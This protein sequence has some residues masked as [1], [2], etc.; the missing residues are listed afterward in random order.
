MI[1]DIDDFKQYAWLDSTEQASV[2]LKRAE[3]FAISIIWDLSSR[4]VTETY[5][6]KWSNI[7]VLDNT[8]VVGIVYIKIYGD[9]ISPSEYSLKSPG[10]I[11]LK[12]FCVEREYDAIEVRYTA[13]Y[14]SETIPDALKTAIYEIGRSYYMNWDDN[15]A[16]ETVDGASVSF[17]EVKAI[18]AVSVINSYKKIYV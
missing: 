18:E 9:E 7:I 11:R 6:G 3:A 13:W 15:I 8:P 12:W 2:A 14:T 16:S 1:L 5:D 10:I 17:K 4:E